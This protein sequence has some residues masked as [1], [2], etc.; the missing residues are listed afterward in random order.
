[1]NIVKESKIEYGKWSMCHLYFRQGDQERSL[2]LEWLCHPF[3]LQHY[4]FFPVFFLW[5]YVRWNSLHTRDRY[6]HKV[7]CVGWG[8]DEKRVGLFGYEFLIHGS[9]ELVSTGAGGE[10]DE[11]QFAFHSI[12]AC[13]L[14]CVLLFFNKYCFF[15]M[16]IEW[17]VWMMVWLNPRNFLSL[18]RI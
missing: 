14:L 1:M 16:T 12:W 15:I 2:S 6:H 8:P 10:G 13:L 17:V 3:T 9:N 11:G 4:C 18:G 5:A 7:L